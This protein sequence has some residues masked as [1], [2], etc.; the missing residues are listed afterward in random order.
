[1]GRIVRVV[2]PGGWHHVTQRQSPPNSGDTDGKLYLQLLR[3]HCVRYGV[4]VT[5]YCLMPNHVHVLA[6]PV[7]ETILA[8]AFGKA[9]T[10]YVPLVEHE[11]RRHRPLLAEP[12]LL[13]PPRRGSPVGSLVLT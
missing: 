5:G 9:H 4:T 10:D 13:V 2:M 3:R 1:M 11:P 6:I 8:H 12:M 7:R